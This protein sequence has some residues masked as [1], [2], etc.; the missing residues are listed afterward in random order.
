MAVA[1]SEVF[2]VQG[3]QND[4]DGSVVQ[5]VVVAKSMEAM[6]ETVVNNRP[7]L[8]VVGFATLDDYER[9]AARIRDALKGNGDWPVLMATGMVA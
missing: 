6:A 9:T 5:I 7:D 4:G 1:K 2:L 3:Q 8:R